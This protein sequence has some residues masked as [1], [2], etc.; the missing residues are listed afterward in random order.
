[1]LTLV[2]RRTPSVRFAIQYYEM[3]KTEKE[4]IAKN[5]EAGEMINDVVGDTVSSLGSK[6]LD[7]GESGLAN[8]IFFCLVTKL[9]VYCY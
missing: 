1:M 8:M 6:R 3:A 4:K 2:T 7:S 9:L 5:I